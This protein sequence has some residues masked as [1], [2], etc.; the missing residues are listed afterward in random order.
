MAVNTDKSQ[1]IILRKD[2]SNI[3][4]NTLQF[5]DEE[6]KWVTEVKYLKLMI[7]NKLTFRQHIQYLKEK[8]WSKINMC[9]PLIGKYSKLSLYIKVLIFKLILRP[10]LMYAA[11]IWDQAVPTNKKKTQVIPNKLLRIITNAP[12]YSPSK[13]YQKAAL[14][15]NTNY[16]A[17]KL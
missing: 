9:L 13:K 14:Y 16:R 1:A 2:H 4:H 11:P 8:F 12:W 17:I 5:F 3:T 10:F 15:S 6:I 7:D